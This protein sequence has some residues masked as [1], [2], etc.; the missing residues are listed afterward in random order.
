ML[1][2][3]GDATETPRTMF[4]NSKDKNDNKDEVDELLQFAMFFPLWTLTHT[5]MRCY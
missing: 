2:K 1:I 3:L 4:K 5:F